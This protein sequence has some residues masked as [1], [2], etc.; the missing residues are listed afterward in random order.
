MKKNA[1]KSFYQE[2]PFFMMVPALV[3]QVLFCYIPVALIL[4]LSVSRGESI[5]EGFTFAHYAEVMDGN[6]ALIILRSLIFAIVNAIFCLLCAY[7]LAYF[8]ARRVKRW[9]N[10]LL[11]LLMVPFWTNILVQIYAWF[12][13]LERNG[14]LNTMLLKLGI[15]GEPIHLV[16]TPASIF[17]VMAYCYLPYM[18][19]PLYSVL[20]KIDERLIES[21]YDL[22]ANSWQTFFKVTVPLSWPGVKTGFFLVLVPSFGEFVIPALMG[23]SK[24]MFVGSL[25]S[26][27]F[28]SADNPH[29]GAAFTVVSGIILLTICL[30]T[31]WYFKKRVGIG[32]AKHG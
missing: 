10:V 2:L 20:E 23:G 14:F 6:H 11:F 18:I 17:I 30:V 3:W 5:F 21:S 19:M 7:P 12:F 32:G 8:L 29:A 28:L 16:N 15:V 27:Y 26:H 13:V 31:V 1:L 4:L 9:K 25:I 22:G 24:S